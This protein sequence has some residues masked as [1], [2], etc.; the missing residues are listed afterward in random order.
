VAGHL[1]QRGTLP[2]RCLS[3]DKEVLAGP[4][5]VPDFLKIDVE[6]AEMSVLRGAQTIL[7]QR[8]PEIFLDTHDF[9]GAEFSSLH[10]KCCR[11]LAELG[12]RIELIGSPRPEYARDVHAWT[13]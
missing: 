11:F 7:S 5:P 13:E 4:L 6:G 2:V 1:S 9:L 8:H 10:S 3:L 12:Y